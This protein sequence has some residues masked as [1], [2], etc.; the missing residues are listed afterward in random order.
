MYGGS[1]KLA[2]RFRYKSP[3]SRS[4]FVELAP[5]YGSAK[6]EQLYEWLGAC[7][8]LVERLEWQTSKTSQGER[9]EA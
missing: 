5:R 6:A 3:N 2:V 1:R 7:Y 8:N 4:A 9:W